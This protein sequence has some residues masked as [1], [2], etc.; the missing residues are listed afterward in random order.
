[1]PYRFAPPHATYQEYEKG[2][3]KWS[4]NLAKK[5]AR[6]SQNL[7]RCCWAIFWLHIQGGL[8]MEPK[9]GKARLPNGYE[10]G[11]ENGIENGI[12]KSIRKRTSQSK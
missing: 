1:M 11:Y 2:P 5:L 3:S 6:W 4:Q 9:V 8:R 7:A 12:E 10:N